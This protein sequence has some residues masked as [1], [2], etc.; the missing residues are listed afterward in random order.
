MVADS[1]GRGAFVAGVG[2]ASVLWHLLLG[3][4]AGRLGWHLTPQLQTALAV[5]GR[6][7]VLGIALRLVLWSL[8]RR[9]R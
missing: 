9:S 3:G 5:G 8:T 6:I 4:A 2:T 1:R 7:A